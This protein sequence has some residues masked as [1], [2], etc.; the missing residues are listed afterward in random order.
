MVNRYIQYDLEFG[1]FPFS[2][3]NREKMLAFKGKFFVVL[4]VESDT[5]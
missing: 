2:H 5:K 3:F 1:W 4:L